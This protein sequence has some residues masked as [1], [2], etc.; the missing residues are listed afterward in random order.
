N[1]A[2]QADESQGLEEGTV[3][4]PRITG[5]K[6]AVGPFE[7]QAEKPFLHVPVDVSEFHRRVPR[8]KV[9]PPAPDDA[10]HVRNDET[11]IDVTPLPRG[12]L[13][14]ARAHPRHRARGRPA[15]EE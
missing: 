11:Q 9:L 14:H 7:S 1:R 13:A 12:Q 6:A 8:A 2:A 5:T 15:M 3:P 4:A 10:I